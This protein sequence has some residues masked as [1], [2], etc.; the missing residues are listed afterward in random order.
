MPPKKV[1]FLGS[2]PIGYECLAFLISQQLPLNLQVAGIL[3]RRRTEFGEGHNLA[4]LAAAH[5]I[6]LLENLDSI[7]E[8]DI[9]YSVQ[10]HQILK[11]EHIARASQIAV[12]LHMAPLPEYRGA[13]QFSFALLEEKAEFGTTI[14]RIDHRI[15]H[16]DILFQKR[17]PIPANCWVNDLYLLTYNASIKLFSQTLKHIIEG[18]YKPVAQELLVPKYG[19]SLHYR[20]E[21]AA[22][23]EIDLNWSKEK[24]ER[25][26]RATS[27]PGFEPPYLFLNGE[28]I[29]LSKAI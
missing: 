16:G 2:K 19:T 23:K 18:N 21:M 4:A 7:P 3:T 22:I 14:H 26:I 5:N 9:I 25:H 10:H 17:F 24:I 15:D 20:S 11:Q 13:N 12:N 8:C 6:P 27:M 29:L 28:K 1:I